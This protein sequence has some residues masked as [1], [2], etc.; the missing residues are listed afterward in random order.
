MLELVFLLIL[1]FLP[2]KYRYKLI[3]KLIDP[4]IRISILYELRYNAEYRNKK[5]L[6]NKYGIE[7]KK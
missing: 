1:A 7:I 5:I 3:K 2:F 6:Y 4:I